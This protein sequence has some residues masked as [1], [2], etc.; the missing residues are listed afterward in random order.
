V[1]TINEI[2]DLSIF[3]RGSN[4]KLKH[5]PVDLASIMTYIQNTLTLGAQEKQ[6]D[7]VMAKTWPDVAMTQ[8][9]VAAL[10]RAFM[11]LLSNAIKYSYDSSTVTITYR[12]ENNRHIVG[13]MDRGIGIAKEDRDKI[14]GGYYRAVNATKT[15]AHGTGLGLFV[16]KLIVEEHHGKVWL[17]SEEGRGT[18]IF[19][20]LPATDEPPRRRTS[21]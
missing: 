11:N 16:S 14:F 19:V 5:E 18:T 13:V 8:G 4:P 6:L 15:Q 10:K 7:I 12:R 3:E 17:D 9:D 21:D 1:S 2:L 20:S